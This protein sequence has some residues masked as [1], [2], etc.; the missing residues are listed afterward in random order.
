MTNEQIIDEA[1]RLTGER[2][3]RSALILWKKLN[4]LPLLDPE[5]KCLYLLNERRCRTALG[6]HEIAQQ[7]LDSVE[8]T[9]T[10][11]QFSLE[12]ELAR[13]DALYCQR[14]FVEAIQRSQRFLKEKADQLASPEF[15][16]IAYEQRLRL[17]QRERIRRRTAVAY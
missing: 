6:Q 11:K 9:D 17:G 7:L 2:E 1:I 4:D 16:L 10:A 8:K 14:K 15:E 12:V 3:Y 13:I 5:S